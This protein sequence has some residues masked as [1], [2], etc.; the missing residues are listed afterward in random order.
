MAEKNKQV[1]FNI[2]ASPDRMCGRIRQRLDR[3]YDQCRV[4]H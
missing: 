1:R 3:E 2:Q 4:P